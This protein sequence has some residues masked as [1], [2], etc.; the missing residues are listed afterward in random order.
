MK[1]YRIWQTV[2]VAAIIVGIVSCSRSPYEKLL[3]ASGLVTLD[4]NPLEGA[5]VAYIP[6]KSNQQQPS[7]GYTDAKGK[8]ALKTPEGQPGV[9]PGEYRI[10]ISR[11]VMEDG[12]PIPPGSQTG[13]AEGHESIPFPH[14]DPRATKNVAV[15]ADGK[16]E[17]NVEI[18]SEKEDKKKK[19]S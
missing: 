11:M 6:I 19:S 3:P 1:M 7:Y 8:Y 5:T 4:G 17:F 12:S 2:M 15:V 14:S 13:A 10:V 9:S 18:V 16:A